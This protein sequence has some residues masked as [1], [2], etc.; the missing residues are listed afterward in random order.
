MEN[1][2][3]IASRKRGWRGE[4][5]QRRGM[6]GFGRVSHKW[7][8]FERAA[9]PGA[10]EA[11]DLGWPDLWGK[12]K[13]DCG[14]ESRVRLAVGGG[15]HRGGTMRGCRPPDRS[16][17]RSQ[18]FKKYSQADSE[19]PA[20]TS[21]GVGSAGAGSAARSAGRVGSVQMTGS[22]GAAAGWASSAVNKSACPPGRVRG[23]EGCARRRAAGL[24]ELVPRVHDGRRV[25]GGHRD[26]FLDTGGLRGRGLGRPDRRCRCGRPPRRCRRTPQEGRSASCYLRSVRRSRRGSL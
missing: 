16:E 7:V 8:D 17:S 15:N 12:G 21:R 18:R 5:F 25:S 19:A 24:I 3:P 4:G 9:G 11:G 14:C 20:G 6:A 23:I 10:G 26:G 2:R 22:R 13:E 1:C